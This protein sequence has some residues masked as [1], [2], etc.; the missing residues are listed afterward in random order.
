MSRITI[1]IIWPC[2][3][4]NIALS[5]VEPLALTAI[6]ILKKAKLV[7]MLNKRLHLVYFLKTYPKVVIANQDLE[8]LG[9]N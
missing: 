9:G 2:I 7:Q 3:F 8:P 5:E 4:G 6:E 1:V